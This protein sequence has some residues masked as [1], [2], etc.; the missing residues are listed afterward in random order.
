MNKFGFREPVKNA[1][2]GIS[3]F[4]VQNRR[5]APPTAPFHRPARSLRNCLGSR[6]GQFAQHRE[7]LCGLSRSG[8]PDAPPDSPNFDGAVAFHMVG[9]EW[10]LWSVSLVRH[11]LGNDRFLRIPADWSLVPQAA[12]RTPLAVPAPS[13]SLRRVAADVDRDDRGE[14]AAGLHCSGTPAL[15]RPS[16]MGSS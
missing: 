5:C 2:F 13:S 12:S 1:P 6:S 15:R 4:H 14:A 7:D 3:R 8:K 16:K 10:R 9:P 11:P